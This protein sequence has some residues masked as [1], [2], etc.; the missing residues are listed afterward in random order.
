MTSI[1]LYYAEWCGH[2]QQFKP[3]WGKL[4]KLIDEY[5]K[6]HKD[7]PIECKEYEA[8]KDESIMK[9]E[10]IQGFP[11]IIICKNKSKIEYDGQ[12]TAETIMGLLTGKKIVQSGGGCTQ[13]KCGDSPYYNKYMKY[14]HKYLMI[15]RQ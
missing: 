10:G 7:D 11:T 2:C 8:T 4:K 6:S 14:K 3:E 13:S 9:Q 15:K 12:R 1:T 5:N